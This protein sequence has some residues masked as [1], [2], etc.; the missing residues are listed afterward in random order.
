[1][2][3]FPFRQCAKVAL[4]SESVK[5]PLPDLQQ[6]SR[7]IR[8]VLVEL[9][10]LQNYWD[11]NMH[12]SQ[13]L[14]NKQLHEIGQTR[15]KINTILDEIEKTTLKELEDKMTSLKAS[16]NTNVGNC[17]KLEN[18]L[19][20]FSDTIHDIADKGKAKLSFIASKKSL[21]K[22][23]QS[24]TYLIEN[25]V[26][27]ESSLTFQAES[28]FQQHLSKL[29]GLGRIVVCTQTVPPHGDL[30]KV[31]TVQGKSKYDVSIPSDGK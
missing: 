17:S 28:Y 18:E 9:K 27:V 11:T 19:K 2:Y 4:I 10:K 7:K 21:E 5:G 13:V 24:E 3:C 23:N 25:L 6:L 20:R 14:Y 12:S 31:L 1:M 29:S 22:I 26:Q 30:E 15:Q 8:T 16:V